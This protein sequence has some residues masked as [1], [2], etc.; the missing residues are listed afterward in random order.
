[1]I[2]THSLEKI[3]VWVQSNRVWKLS[4][5]I[6]SIILTLKDLNSISKLFFV[7]LQNNIFKFRFKCNGSNGAT[8]VTD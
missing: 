5:S 7:L 1:M 2:T 3:K 6:N 4:Y 8:V